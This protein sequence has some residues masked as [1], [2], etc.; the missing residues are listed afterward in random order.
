MPFHKVNATKE[1]N[2]F[3]K[4]NPELKIFNKA[5]DRY[6]ELRKHLKEY[7]ELAKIPLEDIENICNL[8][9]KDLENIEKGIDRDI[10]H[11]LIYAKTLNL[12]LNLQI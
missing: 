11:F 4:K 3:L 9:V 10:V 5:E 7:R 6:Y 8:T 1:L 12:D 2:D